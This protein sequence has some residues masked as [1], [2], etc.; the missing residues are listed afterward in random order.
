[1]IKEQFYTL[2]K[3]CGFKSIREFARHCS[4][5]IGNIHSNASGKFRPSVE[6]M[7]IYAHTLGVEFDVIL[8]IFYRA[9]MKALEDSIRK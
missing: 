7:F 6:R 2:I 5:P 9:E 3:A 4:I 8:S 1:M